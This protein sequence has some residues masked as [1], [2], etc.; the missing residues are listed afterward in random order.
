MMSACCSTH[1]STDFVAGDAD[2]A[3][4]ALD[5]EFMAG[6]ASGNVDQMMNTYGEDAV[7]MPPNA[8][9]QKG[10]AAIRQFWTGFLA[11]GKF[12]LDLIVDDIAQSGDMATE[13]GHY[14]VTVTPAGT[15]ATIR[16]EG[17][18]ILAWR[19]TNGKWSAYA[20]SF[21]SNNPPAPGQ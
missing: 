18:Y 17:K 16:D 7:L 4:R 10:R 19:K 21:S 15:N 2:N 3:I 20:D 9:P 14:T 12:K 8:P 5:R 6:V 11:T 1:P 13:I